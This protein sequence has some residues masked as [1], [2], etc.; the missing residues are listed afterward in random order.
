MREIFQNKTFVKLFFAMV[1]SQMGTIVGNMAFAFYLLD[2]F[3]GQPYLAT[4]AELMYSL[5][6]LVVFLFVGV[7]ADRLDRQKIAEYSDWIRAILTLFLIFSFITSIVPLMFAILFLRSAVSKF[8]FPAEAGLIQGILS[9][10]QYQ[11][12]AGLNMMVHSIFMLFGVGMGAITY[13]LLGIYWAFII[14][15][16]SFVVS[17]M[18]I[19]SCQIHEEARLP[20]GH[21]KIKEL[22]IKQTIHDFKEGGGYILNKKLLLTLI[23]GF[24]LF[25]FINGGFAILPL[26]TMKYKLSPENYEWYASLFGIVFGSGVFAGSALA[27]V[28]GKKFKPYMIIII[29][30]ILMSLTTVSMGL[31]TSIP[32]FFVFVGLTGIIIGPLNV[33]LSGWLPSIVDPTFMGRVNGWIDPIMMLAQSVSLGLIALLFPKI[34]VTVDWI[35]YGIALLMLVIG[36]FYALTLPKLN[37]Q[38]EKMTVEKSMPEVQ[39]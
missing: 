36:I 2:R 37:E 14:D 17:A 30:I 3:S 32:L 1:T 29:G 15:G 5:P 23:M 25:G 6:T 26:F 27:S 11:T 39:V 8:F 34:I 28:I 12:A 16:L 31:S 38:E 19:K 20:N 35:Y 33:A 24:F 18:L 10:E 21:F 4:L 13:K 22:N 9:K 7:L